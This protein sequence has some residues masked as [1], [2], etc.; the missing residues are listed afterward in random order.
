MDEERPE[1]QE[2]EAKHDVWPTTAPE[3]TPTAPAEPAPT[4]PPAEPEPEITLSAPVQPTSAVG[5]KRMGMRKALFGKASLIGAA[6]VLIIFLLL[7]LANRD[8]T[9]ELQ[10]LWVRGYPSVASVLLAGFVC[11][12]LLVLLLGLAFKVGKVH[13]SYGAKPDRGGEG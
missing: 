2:Q 12:A 13:L 6:L 4:A 9:S 5:V 10:F 7:L 11:G 3:S 8:V 1:S